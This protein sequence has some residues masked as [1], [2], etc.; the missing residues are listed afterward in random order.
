MS[1]TITI[2]NQNAEKIGEEKLNSHI[3]GVKANKSLIHQVVVAQL[4]NRRGAYS[5]TKTR[6]QVR[7]GGK[8]PWAQK[9]TGRARVGSI[10]SPLWRGG[11]I[12]FGPTNERNFS[13]KVNKK[14]KRQALLMCLSDKVLE[15]KLFVLDK[16]EIPEIKTKVFVQIL[17]KFFPFAKKLKVIICLEDKNE[18][19]MKSARNIKGVK[20]MPVTNLNVYDLL[21]NENLFITLAGL[22]TIETRLK[23]KNKK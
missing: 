11:G 3:F 6:G 1:S 8:K 2:Y 17:Q 4:A 23:L 13:L 18:T 15:N 5:H 10:R 20:I 9:G 19:A 16:L 12:I 21:S 14:V 22:K 7:G